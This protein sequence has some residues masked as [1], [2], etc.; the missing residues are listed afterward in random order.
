MNIENKIELTG[1]VQYISNFADWEDIE[2][3]QILLDDLLNTMDKNEEYR[4][5]KGLRKEYRFFYGL[6]RQSE[7]DNILSLMKICKR[8]GVD[9]P[10]TKINTE[11][12]EETYDEF[13]DSINEQ[14]PMSDD[15]AMKI[16]GIADKTLEMEDD[17]ME[18]L[19]EDTVYNVMDKCHDI[20]ELQI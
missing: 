10:Q 12:I 11:N 7:L 3:I 9:V 4:K 5:L 20:L 8:L 6:Q 2:D 18:F 1:F 17:F 16:V 13:W 19:N 15:M 14:V